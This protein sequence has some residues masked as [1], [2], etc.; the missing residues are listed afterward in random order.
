MD[1]V[2]PAADLHVVHDNVLE[3]ADVYAVLSPPEVVAAETVDAHVLRVEEGEM[4]TEAEHLPVVVVH[5]V[6]GNLE[7]GDLDVPVPGL[8]ERALVEDHLGELPALVGLHEHDAGAADEGGVVAD[9]D[10]VGDLVAARPVHGDGAATVEGA[11]ERGGVVLAGG[12]GREAAFGGVK[13][14]KVRARDGADEHDGWFHG[15]NS[16]KSQ[17]FTPTAND[18][19]L[20]SDD[21][22][23]GVL[24]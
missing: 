12:V 15:R 7:A 16:T 21:V 17:P 14:E 1:A 2:L 18:K 9:E 19:I 6:H 23:G 4:A 5:A 11:L 13:R 10:R 22:Y 24:L 8:R 3:G 20:D